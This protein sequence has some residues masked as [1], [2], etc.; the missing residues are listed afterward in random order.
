MSTPWSSTCVCS[1]SA[2]ARRAERRSCPECLKDE[3][4]NDKNNDHR[5][6]GHAEKN[7]DIYK[8]FLGEFHG[9]KTI[10][11]KNH[12]NR[13][14]NRELSPR[15]TTAVNQA[16]SDD[17]RYPWAGPAL[18]AAVALALVVFFWWLL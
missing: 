10:A 2:R 6:H 16:P 5:I 1:V 7:N 3:V 14:D 9:D 11:E 17:E 4:V 18:F 12:V 15:I 13:T 8:S